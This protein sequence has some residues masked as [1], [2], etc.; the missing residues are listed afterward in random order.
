MVKNTCMS[1]GL[2]GDVY[3]IGCGEN[4]S[5]SA[6]LPALGDLN[7]D[8]IVD[9]KDLIRLKKKTADDAVIIHKLTGDIN[10]DTVINALD[11][12]LLRKG[13]LK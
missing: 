11:L 1:D 12:V 5:S 4:L 13:L 8:G 6:E 10:R 2:S 9:L 3:C 7:G